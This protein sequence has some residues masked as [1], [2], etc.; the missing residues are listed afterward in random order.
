MEVKREKEQPH[1]QF[2]PASQSQAI[3]AGAAMGTWVYQTVS[4]PGESKVTQ[5]KNHHGSPWLPLQGPHVNKLLPLC[6]PHL[7]VPAV[8]S[9]QVTFQ[10]TCHIY[11][12]RVHLTAIGLRACWRQTESPESAASLDSGTMH[13]VHQ[14]SQNDHCQKTCIAMTHGLERQ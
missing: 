10:V 12:N 4:G 2:R 5:L 14:S 13:I 1:T 6:L 7:T 3:P 11:H 8:T 9:S